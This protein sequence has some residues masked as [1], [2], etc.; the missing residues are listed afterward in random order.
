M[1]PLRVELVMDVGVYGHGWLIASPSAAGFDGA[2]VKGSN[3]GDRAAP[4]QQVYPAPAATG[5]QQL[6]REPVRSLPTPQ[7]PHEPSDR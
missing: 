4:A 1:G 5:M 7:D 3:I 6:E 2:R